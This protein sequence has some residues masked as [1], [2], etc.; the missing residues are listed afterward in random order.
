MYEI[1]LQH[2]RVNRIVKIIQHT[3]TAD[4]RGKHKMSVY[5]SIIQRLLTDSVPNKCQ[6][7]RLTVK[8]RDG[9]H[10]L[11]MPDGL[12]HAVRLDRL[13]QHFRV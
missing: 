3:E 6:F 13:D 4:I 2:L 11:T 5:K 9:K 7:P 1:Q 8:E 10:T 12:C